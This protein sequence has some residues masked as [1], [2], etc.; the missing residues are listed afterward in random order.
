MSYIT[1]IYHKNLMINFLELS[2][3]DKENFFP[4]TGCNRFYNVVERY[5]IHRRK[6]LI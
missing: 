3:I 1:H 4:F 2:I 6:P 5:I